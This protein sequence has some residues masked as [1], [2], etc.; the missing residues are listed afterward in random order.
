MTITIP[1]WVITIA[2]VLGISFVLMF[3]ILGFYLVVMFW[4]AKWWN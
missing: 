2:Q 1:V 3:A 4:D